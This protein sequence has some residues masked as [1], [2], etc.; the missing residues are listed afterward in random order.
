MVETLKIIKQDTVYETIHYYINSTSKTVSNYEDM[1]EVVL[2]MIKEGHCFLMERDILRD[3][4]ETLT[5]MYEL[6]D[7]MNKDR[8]ILQLI[9]IDE[10]D[11]EDG[12]ASVDMLK[13]LG[14]MMGGA[15][16]GMPDM[17][18]MMAGMPDMSQM[19]AGMQDDTD[20]EEEPKVE[21]KVEEKE[22]EEK[23]VESKE[24]PKDEPKV[25]EKEVEP[26]VEDKEV[27]EP[28][29]EKEVSEDKTVVSPGGN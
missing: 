20:E 5:Y 23:E 19:M 4:L 8:I 12:D 26:K 21:P 7:D 3:C 18:A 16:G 1:V 13:N 27:E 15:P 17:S 29:V 9:D 25:E 10:E 28:K 14:Q 22:V 6:Q 11:E 24:E 2:D